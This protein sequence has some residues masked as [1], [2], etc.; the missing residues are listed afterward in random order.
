MQTSA[1]IVGFLALLASGIMAG[2]FYA[3]SFS[4]M[5]GFDRADP[6]HA[7]GG[8]NGINVAVQNPIFLVF[9]MGVPLLL[10]LASVLYWQAG[11]LPSL[12]LFTAAAIAYLVG[13][14]G[15]TVAINVPM[16]N[17]LADTAIP[18][19]IETARDIWNAYSNRWT[20]WN[21]IRTA[22]ASLAFA[23]AALGFFFSGNQQ[24]NGPIGR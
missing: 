12:G 9:F 2:F 8:M 6:R 17:A 13:T 16:N 10:I 14:F 4:A 1:Q 24:I 20:P 7:I 15:V 23:L 3:Y 5:W 21:H 19:D 22:S 18:A 11:H